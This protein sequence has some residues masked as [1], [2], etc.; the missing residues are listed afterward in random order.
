MDGHAIFLLFLGAWNLSITRTPV[1]NSWLPILS[2][3]SSSST[4]PSQQERP[5]WASLSLNQAKLGFCLGQKLIPPLP[6]PDLS[7]F[8][9]PVF[10]AF[11]PL[12]LLECPSF[13]SPVLLSLTYLVHF[14][15]PFTL[16]L[17][18]NP[19]TE[20]SITASAHH[21]RWGKDKGPF[22]VLPH[23]AV[24]VS[25]YVAFYPSLDKL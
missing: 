6:L 24:L 10:Y 21:L 17:S 18:I 19:S 20:L 11:W 25:P 4:P 3:G 8:S 12:S 1:I 7:F 22:F 16:S 5:K 15:H 2:P 14:I 23:G 9:P 13:P